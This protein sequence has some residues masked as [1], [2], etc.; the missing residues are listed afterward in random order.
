MQAPTTGLTPIELLFKKLQTENQRPLK[1]YEL[2]LCTDAEGHFLHIKHE[3]KKT[4]VL[5]TEVFG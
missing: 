2:R 5:T 3:R 4:P 1:R